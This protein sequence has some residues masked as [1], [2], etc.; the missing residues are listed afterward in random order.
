[1]KD[2][3]AMTV[4]RVGQSALP[5]WWREVS[6]PSRG[7]VVKARPLRDGRQSIVPPPKIA[8]AGQQHE[9]L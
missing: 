6:G 4:S 3:D 8:R 5:K 2:L 9:Q 7:G 1:V